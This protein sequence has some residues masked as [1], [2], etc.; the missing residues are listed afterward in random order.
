MRLYLNLEEQVELK[1]RFYLGQFLNPKCLNSYS[2][3]S[4]N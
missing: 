2:T 3:I 1:E 4:N